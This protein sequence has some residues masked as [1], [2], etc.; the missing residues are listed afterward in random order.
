MAKT[1]KVKR[2]KKK[3]EKPKKFYSEERF[4]EILQMLKSG[5]LKTV[6]IFQ[7]QQ[8]IGKFIFRRKRVGS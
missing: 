8:I 7:F 2:S 3:S 5:D 6:S 1:G 4:E